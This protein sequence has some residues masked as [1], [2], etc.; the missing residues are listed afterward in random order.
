MLRIPYALN[1][2]ILAPV[3]ISLLGSSSPMTVV[4]D[5]KI[6]E[7]EGLRLLVAAWWSAILLCSALGLIWP[8]R[9]VAILVLQVI[10]KSLYL[11]IFLLPALLLTGSGSI[12]W[13][14]TNCFIAIVVIWPFFIWSAWR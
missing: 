11:A 10:Y 14:L 12:P 6:A 5:G 3:L 1:I 9:F 2:F 7:S 13:G 8:D 4:F